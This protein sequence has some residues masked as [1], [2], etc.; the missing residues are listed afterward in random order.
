MNRLYVVEST[1]SI[2]GVMADQRLAAR[3]GD[4]VQTARQLSA[5]VGGGSAEGQGANQQWLNAVIKDLNAH[6]GRSLIVPGEYQSEELHTIARELNTAL[7]NVGQ[8]VDYM[9]PVEED[10]VDH[11]QSLEALVDDMRNGRVDLLLVIGGNPVYTAPSDLEFAQNLSKVRLRVHL[12]L[13]EDETS[14]LCQWHIPETH[15]L[16]SW[17]DIRSFDGTA[18]IQQPLIDPLYGSKSAYE[19]LSAVLGDSTKS[20]YEIVREYWQQSNPQGEQFDAWWRKSVH[21]GVAAESKPRP[22]AAATPSRGPAASQ[23]SQTGTGLEVVIRPDPCILEAGLRITHG[24]RNC[25]NRSPS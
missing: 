15:F 9:A 24:C 8:T 6:R 1:L 25:R 11:M 5:L 7:G 23:P 13:Y 3:S 14:E 12:A 4:V 19:I 20:T 22:A 17:G 21:D 10:A 2:T 18:T 16:E